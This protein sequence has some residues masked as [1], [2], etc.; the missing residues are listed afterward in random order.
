MQPIISPCVKICVL[1]PDSK[2]CLG[3][4]RTIGEIGNWSRLTD[5]ERRRIMDELPDRLTQ[6]RPHETN[7]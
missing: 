5:E 4:G 1:D 6:R 3:C 2:M 7:P